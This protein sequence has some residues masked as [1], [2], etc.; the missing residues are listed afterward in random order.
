MARGT[1]TTPRTTLKLDWN[2]TDSHILEFTAVRDN[3][4]ERFADYSFD[5]DT[6]SHGSDKF[7]RRQYHG[8]Y[9]RLYIAKYT[10]YLTD[11]LTLSALVG[12]QKIKHGLWNKPGYNPSLNSIGIAS[13]VVPAAYGAIANPSRSQ[14]SEARP[15]TKRTALGSI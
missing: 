5:Y 15:K 12:T 9:V 7:Q 3:A 4:S 8:G 11:D 6:L 2:I 13:N 14:R 10:G 1:T